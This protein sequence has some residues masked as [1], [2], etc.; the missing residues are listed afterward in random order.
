MRAIRLH[1]FGPA[2]NLR[3]EE[4]ADPE[5]GPGQVRIAVAA[6][7]VHLIDTTIRSGVQMGPLPLPELPAIPGREV[8]GVVDA[9]GPGAD[10]PGSAAAL[11]PT[12][13]RRAPATP[14]SRCAR[15]TTCTRCPTVCRRRRGRD[16]RHR[17]HRDGDPRHRAHRGRRRRPRHRRRRRPR[18]PALAGRAPRRRDGRRRSEPA[19]LDRVTADV[20]VDYTRPGWHEELGEVTVVLDGVGGEAG[21]AAFE[22]L[23]RG[24][25]HVLYGWS[26]GD[27]TEITSGDIVARGL[28]VSSA[29]VRP[30]DCAR[31]KSARRWRRGRPP[32]ITR[33]PLAEAAAAHTAL[34]AA[35]RSARSC[36]RRV[37]RGRLRDPDVVAERVAQPGVGAVEPLGR[38]LGELD[39]L[40]LQLLVGARASSVVKIIQ[41]PRRPW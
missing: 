30:G 39:A 18:R 32:L 29:L 19:K 11:S 24:G 40:R 6:A 14:S 1:D 15:P 21:R 3:Y 2:E 5:P 16:D 38:L 20:V 17:P 41:P 33:F 26:A 25:H 13:E 9:L 28:T 7:G 31:S 37:H 8:A 34:E 4:V 35:K 10:E 12:S 22:L 27:M 23:A 36:L